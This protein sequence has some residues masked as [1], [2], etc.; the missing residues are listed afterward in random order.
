MDLYIP[1]W[2]EVIV[3]GRARIIAPTRE[4]FL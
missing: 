3:E 4:L 2:A 1:S